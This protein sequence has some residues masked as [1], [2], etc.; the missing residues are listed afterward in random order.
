MFLQI[1]GPLLAGPRVGI[2]LAVNAEGIRICLVSNVTLVT[3]EILFLQPQLAFELF[4][5]LC[6]LLQR[7]D[8]FLF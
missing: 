8:G 1:Q 4:A 5:A 2:G 6:C 3:V 7:G